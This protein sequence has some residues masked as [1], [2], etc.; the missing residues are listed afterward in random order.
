MS[1]YRADQLKRF[2]RFSYL[3]HSHFLTLSLNV[4]VCIRFIVFLQISL[5]FY[6]S[7]VMLDEGFVH[8]LHIFI[9]FVSGR[10]GRVKNF[11]D[12]RGGGGLKSFIKWRVLLMGRDAAQYPITCHVLRTLELFAR[13][14]CKFLKKQANFYPILFFWIY[15]K[16]TFHI[17]YVHL[18]QT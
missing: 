2:A 7:R 8:Q 5:F 12:W 10:G 18:S 17:S 6:L 11:E 16:Q 9:F 13:V 3:N 4:K 15:C 14:V 1:I